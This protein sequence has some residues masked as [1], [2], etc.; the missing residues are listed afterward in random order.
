MKKY[1]LF[2]IVIGILTFYKNVEAQFSR[3]QA[4]DLVLNQV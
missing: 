4:I 3:Q 1:L 2:L